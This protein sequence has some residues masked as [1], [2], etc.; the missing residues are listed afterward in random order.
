MLITLLLMTPDYRD[1]ATGVEANEQDYVIRSTVYW[2]DMDIYARSIE[3][4]TTGTLIIENSIIYMNNTIPESGIINNGHLIMNDSFIYASEP[5]FDGGYLFKS[6]GPCVLNN[7]EISR[8]QSIAFFNNSAELDGNRVLQSKVDGFYFKGE[9][10]STIAP[11]IFNNLVQSSGSNGFR[12]LNIN[13]ELHGNQVTDVVNDAFYI[14]NSI[15]SLWDTTVENVNRYAVSIG[16]NSRLEIHQESNIMEADIHFID[17]TSIVTIHEVDRIIVL[18][19][20]DSPDTSTLLL[21]QEMRFGIVSVAVV[22]ALVL[23][24]T[25]YRRYQRDKRKRRFKRKLVDIGGVRKLAGDVTEEVKDTSRG[26][27]EELGDMAMESGSYRRAIEHYDRALRLNERTDE[28]MVKKANAL[29]NLGKK[30]A[31]FELYVEALKINESNEDAMKGI[32]EYEGLMNLLGEGPEGG[33]GKEDPF[34]SEGETDDVISEVPGAEV[35]SLSETGPGDR[36]EPRGEDR[37][38]DD[39]AFPDSMEPKPSGLNVLP[40]AGPEM[41]RESPQRRGERGEEQED[42]PFADPF[43]SNPAEPPGRS[44]DEI[45]LAEMARER[46]LQMKEQEMVMKPQREKEISA[47]EE[48]ERKLQREKEM[49]EREERERKLQNEMELRN[50]AEMEETMKREKEMKEKIQQKRFEREREI[51]EKEE[52]ARR[53][54]S[55]RELWNTQ[56]QERAVRT[57][58]EVR[59]WKEQERTSEMLGQKGTSEEPERMAHEKTLPRAREAGER[60]MGKED[61]P[62]A[63]EAGERMMGKEDL[64]RAREAGERGR[65]KEGER[66]RV[67]EVPGKKDDL[68]S[69]VDARMTRKRSPPSVEQPDPVKREDRSPVR[70]TGPVHSN[71]R[72]GEARQEILARPVKKS[73]GFHEVAGGGRKAR[74]VTAEKSQPGPMMEE[75]LKRA[76]PV[77]EAREERLPV[78]ERFSATGEG[79]NGDELAR[80]E[81]LYPE[82]VDKKPTREETI[83]NELDDWMS[84]KR[85]Q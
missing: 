62:R 37:T 83:S 32:K 46:E 66:S 38:P 82:A 74:N 55:E 31:A 79:R 15:I 14:R 80:I 59:E 23:G 11:G 67:S 71:E 36:V 25:Q 3:I 75:P 69:L 34:A 43:W 51:K 45:P 57:E 56:E 1:T 78:R 54:Q 13:A 2:K 33:D 22:L 85:T 20:A 77:E 73:G 48:Q 24:V 50:K 81:S 61:L 76:T 52:L 47:R 42:D 9:E 58:R 63:R 17:K 53:M 30:D 18:D 19:P 16:E 44:Q 6:Y 28:I 29:K 84:W 60:M 68:V 35:R 65:T 26:V 8:P 7:N 49:G 39:N 10:N 27:Q 5:T 40:P 12:F 64:P 4:N 72:P 70:E 21:S 41:K